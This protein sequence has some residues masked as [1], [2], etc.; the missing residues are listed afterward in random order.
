MTTA[1]IRALRDNSSDTVPSEPLA[2]SFITVPLVP[3][4][5]FWTCPRTSQWLG[6]THGIK[7]DLKLR[8]VVTLPSR[9]VNG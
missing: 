6:D 9:N 8:R 4:H 3:S 1:V 2:Q 5:P 7:D